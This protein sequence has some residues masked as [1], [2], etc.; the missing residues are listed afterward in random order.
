MAFIW[1]VWSHMLIIRVT[2]RSSV[3]I[4]EVSVRASIF[5]GILSPATNI[6]T[7]FIIS[8]TTMPSVPISTIIS[9]VIITSS[10]ALCTCFLSVAPVPVRSEMPLA[11]AGTPISAPISLTI[12]VVRR[13]LVPFS[14]IFPCDRCP[15]VLCHR[16]GLSLSHPARGNHTRYLFF[17]LVSLCWRDR[18]HNYIG[19]GYHFS[20][21]Q[22]IS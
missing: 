19:L 21:S 13:V 5:T 14:N 12:I 15:C 22:I 18:L 20:S 4:T 7:W 2:S 17:N 6:I 8:C 16:T 10:L 9:V 1:S 3:I 11:S